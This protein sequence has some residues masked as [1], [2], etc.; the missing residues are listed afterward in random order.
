MNDSEKVSISGKEEEKSEPFYLRGYCRVC[1]RHYFYRHHIDTEHVQL[2]Q[3]HS[4]V[5]QKCRKKC[6][7][8]D[9]ITRS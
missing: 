9:S 4:G 6:V 8:I 5:C 7:R 2:R 1:N 3:F